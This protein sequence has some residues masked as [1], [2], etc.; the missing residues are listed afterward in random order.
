MRRPDW[1]V[2]DGRFKDVRTAVFLPPGAKKGDRPPAILTIYGGFDSSRSIRE[3]G[4]GD[5]STI[6]APVFTTRG[7]AVLLA[8]APLGPD[9]QPGNPVEELRDTIVPQVY[10][11]AELGY[12]DIRPSE[13]ASV[14]SSRPPEP[15]SV[16]PA[17]MCRRR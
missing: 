9:G 1:L 7:F 11:A 14:T 6:P 8:D 5:V 16:R 4:G 3:Y 12:V 17:K 13:L 10:R 2:R 15:R